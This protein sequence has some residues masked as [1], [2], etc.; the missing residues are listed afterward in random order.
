MLWALSA[1]GKSSISFFGAIAGLAVI[2]AAAVPA[3]RDH[4]RITR[5]VPFCEWNNEPYRSISL[6]SRFAS[7]V[8][9][10]CYAGGFACSFT[11]FFS[12]KSFPLQAGV[13]LFMSAALTAQLFGLATTVAGLREL[14]SSNA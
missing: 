12:M 5:A 11:S 4:R 10:L 3:I 13:A 9:V 2:L 6:R 14:E 8:A 1:G 7:L